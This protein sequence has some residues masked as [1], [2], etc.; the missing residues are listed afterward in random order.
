[1]DTTKTI[2]HVSLCSGYGGI[3][4]GLR[5]AV[6]GIRTIAYCEREA[7]PISILLRRIEEG[8]LDV[9]PIYTDLKTFPWELFRD[10]VSI[11]SGGYPCQP[12][13]A[14]GNRLGKDDPRHLWPWIKDGIAIM[15]PSQC[16]F[17]NVDGHV[18]MGLSTVISDLEELGYK[19]TW[20]VFSAS[21][22][23]AP[24][25]RKRVFILADRIDSGSQGRLLR[26]TN[27]EGQDLDGHIGRGGS[28]V[29]GRWPARP[30]QPQQGWEP[31]RVL[32]NSKRLRLESTGDEGAVG[33]EGCGSSGE[34]SES[35]SASQVSGDSGGQRH[36]VA[37][38]QNLG[39]GGRSDQDGDD[40]LGLPI[41]SGEVESVLRGEAAGC[42]G[43]S[44]ELADTTG[45]S[46]WIEE[47]RDGRE[48]LGG[49]SSEARQLGNPERGGLQGGSVHGTQAEELGSGRDQ[50]PQQLGNSQHAGSHGTPFARSTT[51]TGNYDTGWEDGSSEST[52]ASRSSFGG[53]LP[54][55]D[56]YGETEDHSQTQSTLC[57]DFDGATNRVG[58]AELC[59]T[60]DNRT[61]EL[62]A[63]GNGVVPAQCT[64]SYRTLVD[65]LI[66]ETL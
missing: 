51:S 12:F 52:G 32:V 28:G 65:Q 4:L 41:D 53:D 25:Q 20:G 17:E 24:H 59:S 29:L 63:L 10:Q 36:L 9:G 3:D 23:G 14:A 40:G 2:T 13:S 46:P 11:L 31:P 42:G 43:D 7:F 50:Q 35:S 57:G 19:A 62:R 5:E 47:G 15:R 60:Y 26:W 55:E 16:F 37:D 18:S 34:G 6:P 48:S 58:Y 45:G 39:C 27:P 30:G 33:E 54:D 38:T 22:I 8:Q 21:E 56:G 64:H 61:H 1:V 49:G 44:R 66:N